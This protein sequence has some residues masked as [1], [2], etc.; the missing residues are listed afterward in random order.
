M[1]KTK[2]N[3]KRAFLISDTHFGIRNA[4]VEWMD[5]HSAYFNNFFFPLV[6]EHYK[7]GDILIHI[8]DVYDSRH[9]LNLRAMNMG[10]EI[11]EKLSD[12]FKDGVFVIAGNHDTFNRSSNDINSL[13]SLKW[14]PGVHVMP[15]PEIFTFGDKTVLFMPWRKDHNEERA[16][17]QQ[18]NTADYLFCHTDIRGMRFNK[19][20]EIEDGNDV[21]EFHDFKFVYSGHI[22]YRQKV[23]N[24][25]MVGSPYQLTRSDSYNKKG[26]YIIDFMS[27]EETFFENTYSPQFI[28]LNFSDLL[29]LTPDDI[30]KVMRN[31]YV[32]V[33][34]EGNQLIKSPM[35]V[36]SDLITDY[37]RLEFK[38][39][40]DSEGVDM[41]D[42]LEGKSFDLLEF[43]RSYVDSL[44]YDQETKDRAYMS[45]MKLHNIAETQI[46]NA[47]END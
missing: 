30:N 24:I 31:N 12:L 42:T 19:Y 34:I 9:S 20:T 28:K 23:R 45:I 5:T 11:F 40:M 22:H 7:P 25:T 8:G 1:I 17:L 27:G 33:F 46:N 35:N 47:K 32:D 6:K 10:I 16:C 18:F 2:E 21:E 36:F 14:I 3:V 26:V 41:F 4:S 39:F 15:E 37:K 29:E 43:V 13:K 44:G 38:P